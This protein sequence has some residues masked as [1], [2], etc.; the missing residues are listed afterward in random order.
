VNM[1]VEQVFDAAGADA[2]ADFFVV[3]VRQR[4]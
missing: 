2:F 4:A 3:D 1:A